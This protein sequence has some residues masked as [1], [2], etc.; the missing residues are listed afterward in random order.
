[1]NSFDTLLFSNENF[2]GKS[3]RFSIGNYNSTALFQHTQYNAFF[4][5]KL[6][7]FTKIRMYGGDTFNMNNL[8]SITIFNPTNK[9]IDVPSFPSNLAGNIK[10]ISITQI[11]NIEYDLIDVN[12]QLE[13]FSANNSYSLN[14]ASIAIICIILLIT[15]FTLHK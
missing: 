14:A 11:N 12:N 10:S 8:G 1:M 4:S 2:A 5:L 6:P 13:H 15:Y 3:F 7:P 9:Y